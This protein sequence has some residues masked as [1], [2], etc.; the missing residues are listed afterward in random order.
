MAIKTHRTR[1]RT[2]GAAETIEEEEEEESIS[3]FGGSHAECVAKT[4]ATLWTPRLVYSCWWILED[5][6][7]LTSSRLDPLNSRTS[8]P[9]PFASLAAFCDTYLKDNRFLREREKKNGIN[10]FFSG[11]APCEKAK[12]LGGYIYKRDCWLFVVHF[13]RRKRRGT[14]YKRGS[15][16][17][18]HIKTTIRSA[19]ELKL[20][21]SDEKTKFYKFKRIY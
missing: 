11:T 7:P 21:F 13:N 3:R 16:W 9:A 8:R 1:R 19:I 12:S 10:I 6:S 4:S 15:L 14:I 5:L 2:W 18:K 20:A 17:I